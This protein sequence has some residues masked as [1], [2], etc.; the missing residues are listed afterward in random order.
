MWLLRDCPC[1]L[2]RLH[3]HFVRGGLLVFNIF[4]PLL[5][6]DDSRY[7]IKA[8]NGKSMSSELLSTFS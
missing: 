8:F 7:F 6:G 2:Q 3:I 4:L 5:A 1:H